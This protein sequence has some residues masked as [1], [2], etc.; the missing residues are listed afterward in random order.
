MM[1]EDTMFGAGLG[2]TTAVSDGR[3]ISPD[4]NRFTL[5]LGVN[6]RVMKSLTMKAS[7]THV[8]FEGTTLNIASPPQGPWAASRKSTLTSLV[9]AAH[10]IGEKARLVSLALCRRI[11]DIVPSGGWRQACLSPIGSDP[12]GSSPNEAG[13][14]CLSNLPPRCQ[15]CADEPR[16]PAL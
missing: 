10:Y 15:Q 6:H 16:P 2:Y 8:F 5:S 9:S 4:G 11:P 3:S 14:G 12:E 13:A 7:Y 1:N